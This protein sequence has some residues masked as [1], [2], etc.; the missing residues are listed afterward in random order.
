MEPGESEP[1]VLGPG[2]TKIVLEAGK[3]DREYFRDLWRYRELFYVLAWRDVSVRY[4]Q[5]AVGIAWAILRPA[6]TTIVFTLVFG[7]L[8][9]FSSGGV[10]YPVMVLAGMLPWQLF[11]SA[12]T[13]SG[14]SLVANSN[15]ITKVYFP[16][17]IIPG[18]SLVTSLVDFTISGV[19]LAI[20]MIVYKVAPGWQIIALPLFVLVALVAAAG[21]GTWVASL[22]VKYRDFSF[23]VPFIVQLGLYISPVGFSTAV[24]PEKW[25]LLYSLNPMVGVIDGFRWCLLGGHTNVGSSGFLTS[26]VIITVVALTGVRHFRRTERA[27]ADII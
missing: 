19:L 9:G 13:D 8:G 26:L 23:V 24:V 25:R 12:L 4:K 17:I 3:I 15:L 18:S 14:Q 22:N 10:P 2:K 7:R 11:A 20:V 21:I 27:F 16:R 6:V 1:S 5:T